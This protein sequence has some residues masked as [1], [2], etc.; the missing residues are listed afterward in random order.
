M[1]YVIIGL[2]IVFIVTIDNRAGID[3]FINDAVHGLTLLVLSIA[4]ITLPISRYASSQDIA[5]HEAYRDAYNRAKDMPDSLIYATFIN[6]VA[7]S[8]GN[9]ARYKR[10]NTG[11]LDIYIVDEI[12]EVEPIK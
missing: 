12:M 2:I 9:L 10:A 11:M 4:L 5:G 8:N 1:E 7:S 6:K 3:G